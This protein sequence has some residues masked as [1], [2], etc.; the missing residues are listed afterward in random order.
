MNHC[1]LIFNRWLKWPLVVLASLLVLLVA[2]VAVTAALLDAGYLHE[3]IRKLI[4]AKAGREIRV[5]GPVSVHLFSWHPSFTAENVVIHNPS[6]MPPG[7]MAEIARMSL[8]LATPT[9]AEPVQFRNLEL[10]GATFNL[11]RQASGNANWRHKP[12]RVG[13][14]GPP[15]IR[16]FSMPRARVN[17]RDD[18]RHL[19]F[20]GRMSAQEGTGK[21]KG[22]LRLTGAGELNT[23]DAT[24]V[25]VGDPLATASRDKPYHFRFEE[26]SS[27]STFTGQGA[28]ARYLDPRAL[29]ATLEAHGEDLKDLYYLVGVNFPDTGTYRIT[30]RIA[31]KGMRFSFTDLQGKSG[32][33]D[34]AGRVEIDSGGD[35]PQL[36]ADV[37]SERLR[38][39]DLG[40]RAANRAPPRT[41]DRLL[42]PQEPIRLESLRRTDST[43]K[44]TIDT[45]TAGR[46]D[47]QALVAQLKVDHGVVTVAPLTAA[48]AD[49]TMTG[50]LR[51]DASRDTPSAQVEFDFDK[52]Q[53]SQFGKRDG[54][55]PPADGLLR[56]RLQL[57]GHGRSVHE[58]ARTSDGT[59]V[60][61]L[62]HG[63]IRATL[64]E[65]AG[66]DFRSLGLLLSGSKQRMDVRCAV[67]AFEV[68]NGALRSQ[69][70]VFDT[71]PVLFTGK[72][73]L[74]LNSEQLDFRF[75]GH[76]KQPR[77]RLR[78]A[79][80]MRGTLADPSIG[81]ESG[82]SLAQ[83]GAG[84]ALGVLLTPL[85]AIAAF[86]D[87]GRAEDADCAALIAA[88]SP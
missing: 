51:F 74:D 27:G 68:R 30:G 44:Y 26:H 18:R 58:L 79:L 25:I 50:K 70:L 46:L 47:L 69:A 39:A 7:I 21:D 6:W 52:L 3:P 24:F 29:Q 13:G 49:G 73:M 71:E 54:G 75:E 61:I 22:R 67:G 72:G 11:L 42:L 57:A 62:P 37:H 31:R 5:T 65:L 88:N 1:V 63:E 38:L 87:P 48:F 34:I 81:V 10:H 60:V 15:L 78:T 64:A 33:S 16:S 55:E 40:K 36:T 80:T 35:R 28:L 41:P 19:R 17:L 32:Q 45:V 53:L 23:R 9:F 2:A 66:I 84:I 82:R 43:V 86:I 76:P 83:A 20:S 14:G 56:G 85:A 12:G 77:L 4:V 59:V 8:D